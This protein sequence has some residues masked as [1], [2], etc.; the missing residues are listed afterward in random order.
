MNRWRK[1]IGIRGRSI[2]TR[3]RRSLAMRADDE[4]DAMASMTPD[5][6]AVTRCAERATPSTTGEGS[7]VKSAR[8]GDHA[9]LTS[10][11]LV[12]VENPPTV[13][14]SGKIVSNI[15]VGVRLGSDGGESRRG[16]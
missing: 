12:V 8:G 15:A 5:D 6:G 11:N 1:K 16:E 13:S 10:D 4:D 9:T 3:A 2:D 7:S 14:E